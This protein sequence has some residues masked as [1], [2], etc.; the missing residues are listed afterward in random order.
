M[1]DY[2]RITRKCPVSHLRPE[3]R[4]AAL[5][6]FQ[7]QG[8]ANEAENHS[9]TAENH[10]LTTENHSFP[11]ETIRCYE[12]TSRRK[13]AGRLASWLNGRLDTITCVAMIL[14]PEQLIWVRWGD[15][16]GTLLTAANLREIKVK[17]YA[18]ILAKDTGLEVYGFIG[19][20]KSRGRGYL[21]MESALIAQEFCDQVRQ[22]I[23]KVNPPPKRRPPWWPGR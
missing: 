5:D 8:L 7:S 22:A 14:T 20:S 16:S 23:D 13:S 21:G 17:V 4:N 15:Q 2:T 1:S 6:Y 19:D 11:A 18:S 12:T 9:L 3:L 10:N